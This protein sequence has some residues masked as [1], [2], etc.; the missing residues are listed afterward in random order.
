MRAIRW[1]L[2]LSAMTLGACSTPP[3]PVSASCPPPPP[4]PA[5]LTDND[6]S[7]G[8]NLIP[9][10]ESIRNARGASMKTLLDSLEKAQR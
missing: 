1:L 10:Y 9:R 8:A 4:A 2:L 5:V 7:T 6:A 3:V